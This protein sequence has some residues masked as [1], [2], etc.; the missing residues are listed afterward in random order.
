MFTISHLT[1]E[2]TRSPRLVGLVSAAQFA[3][4]MLGPL[5]GWVSD[6]FSRRN[7]NILSKLGV[8][9]LTLL[10]SVFM[11]MRGRLSTTVV[12]AAGYLYASNNDEFCIS[13]EKF[14]SKTRNFCLK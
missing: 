7:L 4:L 6:K 8:V 13:K 3:A 1:Q 14:V 2:L 12:L 5:G 9:P 11:G 10:V